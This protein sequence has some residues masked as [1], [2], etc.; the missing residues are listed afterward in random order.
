MTFTL[1]LTHLH[2]LT[3]Y[4][5]SKY[6]SSGVYCCHPPCAPYLQVDCVSMAAGR[7]TGH[8]VHLSLSNE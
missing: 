6:R 3:V 8:L 4:V 1:Y 2:A 5:K 7:S